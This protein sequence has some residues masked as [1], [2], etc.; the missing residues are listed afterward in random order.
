M[1]S[2]NEA[3]SSILAP[4]KPLS[5]MDRIRAKR[6]AAGLAPASPVVAP[7]SFKASIP[8]NLE[9]ADDAPF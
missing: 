4:E 9:N 3:S 5:A 7:V 2:D 1:D 8:F 6:A